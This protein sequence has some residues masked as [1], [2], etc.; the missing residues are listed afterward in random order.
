MGRPDR[1]PVSAIRIDGGQCGT[2]SIAFAITPWTRWIPAAFRYRCRRRPSTTGERLPQS[3]VMPK[4][5]INPDV[6]AG[7]GRCYAVAP[8]VFDADDRGHGMVVAEGELTADQLS[9]AE[10]AI[11][12][13]PEQAITLQ[14]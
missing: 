12:N 9:A 6:C 3:T 4:V 8:D 5:R 14:D 10:L 1:I 13:C 2:P 7:H 11:A